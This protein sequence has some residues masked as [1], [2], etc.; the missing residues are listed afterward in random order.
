[1]AV[2]YNW[3]N[4]PVGYWL[5]LALTSVTD[6]GFILFVVARRSRPL[7]PGLLGPALWGWCSVHWNSWPYAS[8]EKRFGVRHIV[9]GTTS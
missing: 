6:V 4:N 3:L 8:D 9:A 7:W 2:V 1:M 5:N